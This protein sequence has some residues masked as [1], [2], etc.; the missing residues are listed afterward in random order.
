MFSN[1]PS[2][3]RKGMQPSCISNIPPGERDLNAEEKTREMSLKQ[4]IRARTWI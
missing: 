1:V 3:E 4:F 2:A